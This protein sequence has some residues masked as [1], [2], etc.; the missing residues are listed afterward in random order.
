[1]ATNLNQ[2]FISDAETALSG[3]TFNG[4]GDGADD[5]GIWNLDAAGAYQ[6]TKLYEKKI[7]GAAAN[8]DTSD[9]GAA[10]DAIEDLLTIVNP[11]WTL[12]R[13]QIVQRPVSGNWIA[14]PMIDTSA[15]KRVQYTAHENWEGAL[16]TITDSDLNTAGATDGDT[17]IFKFIIRAVPRNQTSF[18]DVS[19]L[20]VEG[21]SNAF[22]LGAFH[23]TNHK[24]INMTVAIA[25]VD[26]A[27]GTGD[28][29]TPIQNAIA[30]HP[31]LKDMVSAA[32]VGANIE[33]SSLH[34]GL[35]FN[36]L[37]FNDTQGT[38]AQEAA[39]TGEVVGTGND[40]QVYDDEVRCRYKNGNFNRMYFPQP[41]DVFTR[42]G[43][44]YDK[45]TIEYASPNWPNGAGIVPAGSCNI[46]TI[47]YTNAGTAPS[48]GTEFPTLFDYAQGTDAEFVW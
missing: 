43:G 41:S 22:P 47:Y 38:D 33:I 29:L 44:H 36:L 42:A 30:A 18:Y 31:I 20:A 11:L 37:I 1:M 2:V 45:I 34:P 25:H 28:N 35:V 12:R 39:L 17:Y 6:A 24:A 7:A 3:S 32:E 10:D 26:D 46:A 23:T 40:W 5:V 8:V 13:F 21:T 9:A 27:V 4:S 48:S 14:S 16:C 19:T 15:V